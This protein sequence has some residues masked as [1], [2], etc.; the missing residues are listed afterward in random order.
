M[1]ERRILEVG[2]GNCPLITRLRFNGASL[3]PDTHYVAIDSSRHFLNG[4]PAHLKHGAKAELRHVREDLMSQGVEVHSMEAQ[5]LNFPDS[6]FDSVHFNNVLNAEELKELP[7][8]EVEKIIAEAVRVLK[9]GGHLVIMHDLHNKRSDARE[10]VLSANGMEEL[11][12]KTQRPAWFS[13]IPLN[14]RGKISA[15]ARRNAP[16][17]LL[18]LLDNPALVAGTFR[19][20]PELLVFVKK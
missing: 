16:E 12:N 1:P 10:R 5:R 2:H 9:P 11:H 15:N 14:I 6:H 20:S 4:I 3:P 19:E 17:W 18:Q 13:N 7:N 8:S